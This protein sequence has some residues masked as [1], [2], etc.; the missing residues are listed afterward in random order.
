[1][2]TIVPPVAR[3][4]TYR[5]ATEKEEKREYWQEEKK[6]RRDLKENNETSKILA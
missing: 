3:A 1:M 4:S 5:T 6:S 2:R